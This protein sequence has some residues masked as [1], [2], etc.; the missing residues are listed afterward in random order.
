MS[1]FFT[2]MTQIMKKQYNIQS[3]SYINGIS[4]I[5]SFIQRNPQLWMEKDVKIN[6]QKNGR[7]ILFTMTNESTKIETKRKLIFNVSLLLKEMNLDKLHLVYIKKYNNYL[8]ELKQRRMT[9]L[10]INF[11][12]QKC[13][14]MSLAEM[15]KKNIDI[16]ELD[17]YTLLYNLLVFIDETP[18]LDYRTLIYDPTS[19]HNNYIT[20]DLDMIIINNYKTS[21]T[22]G[23]W[24][25]PITNPELRSYLQEYIIFKKSK[26]ND[27][28]FSNQNNN[29]FPSNKFSEFVQQSF[30]RKINVKMNIN[31]LRKVKQRDLFHHNPKKLHM[32]IGEQRSFIIQHFRHSLST[33]SEY[34]YKKIDLDNNN[35]NKFVAKD[36]ME[37]HKIS[38][39]NHIVTNHKNLLQF[40][41]ELHELMKNFNVNHMQVRKIL[42]I[43][44]F[45]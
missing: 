17:Q 12:E 1:T 8:F 23:K 35:N 6:F 7:K 2:K 11:K 27:K 10:P 41:E 19:E 21:K 18:R 40:K 4:G 34:Y 38:R 26:S 33:A 5:R 16:T 9:S 36:D 20:Q 14:Q 25:I 29:Y 13:L 28:F 42:N 37:I 45:I 31:C 43:D 24:T 15:R 3:S 30:F 32:S 22:Y 39:K 44:I